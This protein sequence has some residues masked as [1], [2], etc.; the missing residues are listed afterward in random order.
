MIDFCQISQITKFNVLKS[1]KGTVYWMA[2]E[3]WHNISIRLD[4]DMLGFYFLRFIL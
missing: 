4:L 3:V 2:P 1:C